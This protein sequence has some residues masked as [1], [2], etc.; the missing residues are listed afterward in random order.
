MAKI[1]I[2]NVSKLEAIKAYKRA[3]AP[4]VFPGM[5]RARTFKDRKKHADKKAC[6]GRVK[7]F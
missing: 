3:S 5:N 2:G 4:G 1:K 7:D 6:R